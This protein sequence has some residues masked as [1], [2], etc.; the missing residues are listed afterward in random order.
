MT[1]SITAIACAGGLAFL[2]ALGT[3]MPDILVIPAA[4]ALA[5]PIGRYLSTKLRLWAMRASN[6]E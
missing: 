4:V 3:H 5:Y 6:G 1:N 2:Q